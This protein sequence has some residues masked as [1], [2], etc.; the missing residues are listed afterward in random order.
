MARATLAAICA[1]C[2]ALAGQETCAEPVDILQDIDLQKLKQ[3]DV[4]MDPSGQERLR[5]QKDGKGI[6]TASLENDY[7]SGEDNGYTN[8]VRFAW[9]SA[10]TDIPGWLEKTADFLPFFAKNGHRRYGFAVGQSMFTPNNISDPALIPHDRP[11]AGWLYG[12]AGLI[13]DTGYRLDNLQ[14]T[15][16]MVGPASRA[17]QTQD[18]VHHTVGTFDPQ[19]WDHQLKNEPGIILTYERQWRAIVQMQPF[20]WGL[21][22]TPHIGGSVGNIYTYASAGANLRFGYDLP[23]DYGPPLI[24]PSL[25]GSDFFVPSH[26]LGWYV[27]AGL[28]G[29]AIAR[30]IFLDGNSWKAS[31]SVNKRPFVGT[32]QAG[33]AVSYRDWRLAYTQ[34]WRSREFDGQHYDSGFGALT[35]STRF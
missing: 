26:R 29:R 16:G 34:N 13:S 8:G 1:L 23:S 6:F 4:E 21:D 31:H 19:G 14:L 7:F 11:Y 35:L 25:P 22:I 9:T 2:L 33:I 28:E 5:E 32:L 3:L 17:A 12:S 15:L 27:F 24:R 20:G 18:F 30:D 10:E